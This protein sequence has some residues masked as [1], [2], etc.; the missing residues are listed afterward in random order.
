[1]SDNTRNSMSLIIDKTWTIFLDRDGVINE[2]LP[3]DYVKDVQQFKFIKG[4]LEAIAIFTKL[5]GHI[6]VVSNQQG[7][8][9]GL[10]TFDDLERVHAFMLSE[11]VKAEGKID[12]IYVSMYLQ[13][14]KHFTRKPAVGMGILARKEFRQISFRRSVMVGDSISDMIFGKRLGMKTVFI[15]DREQVRN[16]P[17]LVDFL[18]RDLITFARTLSSA[19]NTTKLS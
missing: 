9:K 12:K 15:G 3:D 10:M 8:G 19:D 14:Q 6:I 13:S 7:I 17:E 1:M 16:R 5:F 4:T 2:R 18:Y 11:V